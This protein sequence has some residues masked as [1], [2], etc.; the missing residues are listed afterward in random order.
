MI[1]TGG[2]YTLCPEL[3]LILSPDTKNGSSTQTHFSIGYYL[4]ITFECK[5]HSMKKGSNQEEMHAQY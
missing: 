3:L 1:L 5:T 2:K 4:K